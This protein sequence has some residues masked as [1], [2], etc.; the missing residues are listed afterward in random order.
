MF[1]NKIFIPI[2][3]LGILAIAISINF[4]I[5][6]NTEDIVDKISFE[7]IDKDIDLNTDINYKIKLTNNTNY[8]IVGSN[9]LFSYIKK[10]TENG[11]TGNPFMVLADNTKAIIKPNESITL[12]V[13]FPADFYKQFTDYELSK[14]NIHIVGYLKQIKDSNKI[15]ITKSLNLNENI[16]KSGKN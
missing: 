15:Y 5:P 16:Y 7:L 1:K 13:S 10:A 14:A 6:P 2:L 3:V 9:I 12:N 4:M 8:K 11:H